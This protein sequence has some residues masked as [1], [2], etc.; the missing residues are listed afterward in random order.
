VRQDRLVLFVSEATF[1][2][3]V[4]PLEGPRTLVPRFR[5]A[6]RH[7]LQALGVAAAVIKQEIDPG[8]EVAI[9]PTASRKILGVMNDLAFLAKWE[10][11]HR[12]PADLLQLSLALGQVP[13]GPLKYVHPA[14][15]TRQ[16][17]ARGPTER[18]SEVC[19]PTSG[20]SW[21]SARSRS[22]HAQR[23]RRAGP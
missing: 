4:I 3:V 18:A 6:L 13:S 17:L 2:P 10:L 11:E 1:L 21:R 14:E 22:L 5:T 20:S 19:N 7:M 16:H 9:A 12:P 15:A 8:G 23:P